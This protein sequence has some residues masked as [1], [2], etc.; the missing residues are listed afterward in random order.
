MWSK[1]LLLKSLRTLNFETTFRMSFY[2]PFGATKFTS[3]APIINV[4]RQI[5]SSQHAWN[6]MQKWLGQNST[7]TNIHQRV[8]HSIGKQQDK[9]KGSKHEA[10]CITGQLDQEH[11]QLHKTAVG[12]TIIL[13]K[14]SHHKL[15]NLCL[16]E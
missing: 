15:E 2:H 5:A 10:R 3:V 11:K 16:P 1:L 4:V 6:H 12:N 13:E 14:V 9:N 7:L 8:W